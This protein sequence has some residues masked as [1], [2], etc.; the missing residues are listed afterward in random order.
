MDRLGYSRFGLLRAQAVQAKLDTP[1]NKGI[2]MLNKRFGSKAF[3]RFLSSPAHFVVAEFVQL[4]LVVN[5]PL[6]DLCVRPFC[7]YGLWVMR[8][9]WEQ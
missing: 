3:D 8:R 7:A 5:A 4:W 6:Y 9:E 1:R 2:S